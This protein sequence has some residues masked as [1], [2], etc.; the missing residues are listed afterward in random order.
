V[1][2]KTA[3][4]REGPGTDTATLLKVKRNHILALIDRQ[5]TGPWWNVIHIDSGKEG[6]I[7]SGLVKIQ[8][9]Q[10]K[11]DA[12]LF[13]V[14]PNETEENPEV[15]IKNDSSKLLSLRIGAE[16][17]SLQPGEEKTIYQAP[18]LY[19]YH[20]SAPGV[21]PKLGSTDFAVGNTYRWRF[22]IVTRTIGGGV[23]FRRRR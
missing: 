22:Y 9:T 18:G 10:K 3:N 14:E 12:Q 4:L 16:R 8:Y 13:Q 7:H 21:I 5:N 19:S 11:Q 23:R 6:W 17:H 1:T 20:A 15:V 2:V